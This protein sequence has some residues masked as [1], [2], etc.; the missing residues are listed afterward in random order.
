[1]VIHTSKPEHETPISKSQIRALNILSLP[2]PTGYQAAGEALEA[3]G[4]RSDAIP[5]GSNWRTAAKLNDADL[6]EI[7]RASCRERV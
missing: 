5:V 2:L 6:L 1:M 3:A 4:Y 7:G